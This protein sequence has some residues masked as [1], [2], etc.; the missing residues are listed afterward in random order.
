MFCQRACVW[1][2]EG[3]IYGDE[4]VD[5]AVLKAQRRAGEAARAARA[6]DLAEF[7]TARSKA[8]ARL[9]EADQA[10]RRA[11]ELWGGERERW[12]QGLRCR[13]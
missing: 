6:A 5:G 1:Q 12:R 4:G 3:E 9:R 13:C 10:L 8:R 7:A 11:A 2:V